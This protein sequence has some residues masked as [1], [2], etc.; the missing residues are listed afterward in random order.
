[1][2]VKER[3]H[4]YRIPFF[5][6]PSAS[7]A[8]R[9][10]R[11]CIS[12]ALRFCFCHDLQ[13][14]FLIRAAVPFYDP[15]QRRD[16]KEISVKHEDA[17]PEHAGRFSAAVDHLDHMGTVR[18]AGP[19]PGSCRTQSV[20]DAHPERDAETMA[21]IAGKKPHSTKQ[22]PEDVFRF[23][24]V[25]GFLEEVFDTGHVEGFLVLLD[26][27][28]CDNGFPVHFPAWGFPGEYLIPFPSYTGRF[29]GI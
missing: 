11:F 29:P 5:P 28:S 18:N 13:S 20:L 14:V 9:V 12:C 6:G 22:V 4:F 23:R 2:A 19:V 15:A 16:R 17:L 25:L 21:G 27:V 26:A 3:E 8:F 10:N 1:M 7:A 24:V